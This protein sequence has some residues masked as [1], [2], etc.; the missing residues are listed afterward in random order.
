MVAQNA[1]EPYEGQVGRHRLDRQ[2]K[3]RNTLSKPVPG[4]LA[5]DLARSYDSDADPPASIPLMYDNT[6]PDG[7]LSTT[8]TDMANFMV[9]EL[10]GGRYG[11]ASILGAAGMA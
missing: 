4:A 9:A 3:P 8:A 7:A 6:P 2:N 11:D 10:D 5:G 1:A